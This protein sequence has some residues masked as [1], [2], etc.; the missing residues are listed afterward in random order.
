M[1]S[2]ALVTDSGAHF[3]KPSSEQVMSVILPNI[4]TVDNARLREGIDIGRAE[5][6]RWLTDANVQFRVESPSVEDYDTVFRNLLLQHEGVICICPTQELTAH[7]RNALQA[8]SQAS[9]PRRIVVIDSES[10]ALGQSFLSKVALQCILS[11]TPLLDIELALRAGRERLFSLFCVEAPEQIQDDQLFSASHRAL[12][13]ILEIKPFFTL[14]DGR[15]I[16][17]EK[18]RNKTQILDRF[19]EFA[20]DFENISHIGVILPHGIQEVGQKLI[21]RLRSETHHVIE[22][23]TYGFSLAAILGKQVIG[24]AIME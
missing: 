15:L 24:I 18:T 6:L 3:N 23:F 20:S 4:V 8:A 5:Q 14:E 19:A 16:A 22:V 11:N 1:K 21:E 9:Q 7:Y 12:S 2:I 17:V 10:L 13:S